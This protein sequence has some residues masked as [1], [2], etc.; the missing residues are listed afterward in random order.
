MTLHER[1]GLNETGPLVEVDLARAVEAG[2]IAIGR[3]EAELARVAE[4]FG[5]LGPVVR[6]LSGAQG[7]VVVTGLGKSG[8]VG[9]KLAATLASTGTPAFFV[10]A[11]DALHGDSGAL[12]SGDILLAISKSGE[13][14]EVLSFAVIARDRGIPVVAVTGCGGVSS[15]ARMAQLV[16]DTSVDTEADPWDTVPTASTSVVML[17][18][19][20]LAISLMVARG[21]K[22]EDFHQCHPAG[23]IGQRLG[24]KQTRS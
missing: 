24:G 20:A 3:V 8:L 6:L 23:Q 15:L 4:R 19:D 13:T 11:A 5:R 22:R 12:T 14:E 18:G 7:H 16:V 10:H 2:Q 17:I 21:W 9:A 1:S